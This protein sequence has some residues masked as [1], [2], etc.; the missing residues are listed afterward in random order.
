M[1]VRIGNMLSQHDLEEREDILKQQLMML[2]EWMDTK[3]RNSVMYNECELRKGQCLPLAFN[4][5]TA[6]NKV[7]R[8]L[9]EDCHCYTSKARVPYKLIFEATKSDAQIKESPF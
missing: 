7:V 4:G 3:N 2:N 1:L 5:Q 6:F 9:H 8:L